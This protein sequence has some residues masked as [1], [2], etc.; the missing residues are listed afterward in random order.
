MDEVLAA[1]DAARALGPETVL[2]TSVVHADAA[3][4]TIDMIAVTGGRRLV[5]DHARCC[6][7]PSPE[8]AT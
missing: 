8:P 5:G 6:R 4:D 1:A 2:V 3:P 7:G